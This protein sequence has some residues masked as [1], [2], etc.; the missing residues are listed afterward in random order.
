MLPIVSYQIYQRHLKPRSTDNSASTGTHLSDNTTLTRQTPALC[1]TPIVDVSA[2]NTLGEMHATKSVNSSNN[3]SASECDRTL[4][5]LRNAIFVDSNRNPRRFKGDKDAVKKW[6]KEV[7]HLLEVAHISESN[8]L[9]LT[10]YLLHRDALERFNIIDQ[11]YSSLRTDPAQKI[12]PSII[13]TRYK[14][15]GHEASACFS[16]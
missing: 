12:F 3:L 9:D 1:L 10:S 15:L 5:D 8:R 14:H 4:I 11:P 13:C 2:T 7:E 16:F 6:I